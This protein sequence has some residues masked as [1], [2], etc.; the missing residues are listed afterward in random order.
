MKAKSDWLRWSA[1]FVLVLYMFHIA[2]NITPIYFGVLGFCLL[3]LVIF[4]LNKID[5]LRFDPLIPIVLL[6]WIFA[7]IVSTFQLNRLGDPVIGIFRM[8]V[9][10]PLILT[11]LVLSTSSIRT[12]MQ[13]LCLFFVIAAISLCWQYAFGAILWLA[14]SSERAGSE[15]FASLAGSLTSYGT[16]I[17]V[18]LLAA[19]V[20][21]R[22]LARVIVC[23]FLIL[24]AVLSLQKAGLANVGFALVFA[25]WIGAINIRGINFIVG[26]LMLIAIIFINYTPDDGVIGV[27]YRLFSGYIS[28]DSE[29]VSDVSFQDSILDRITVL[30]IEV[31]KFYGFST[32]IIGAGVFGGSG[33]L[34]Y[35]D[36]PMA[37]NGLMELVGIFGFFIGG[38]FVS[39]LIYFF[40]SSLLLLRHRKLFIN[41]EIAFLSAS[42]VLWFVNYLFSG[43][44]LFHPIGAAIFWLLIFRIRMVNKLN[45]NKFI[46]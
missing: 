37:H 9:S 38:I 41:T 15:R 18:V 39:G 30:P 28:S 36:L 16:S 8:W 43:G 46:Y 4:V 5:Q 14:D 29:F 33:V 10:I 35:P 45:V 21:F 27:L 31:Y 26:T 13:L 19:F 12:S 11:S 6:I 40:I 2:R 23:F 7:T 24:G 42:Y 20:Y 22:G 25:F 17:G 1:L 34:G 32:L 3:I 44:A